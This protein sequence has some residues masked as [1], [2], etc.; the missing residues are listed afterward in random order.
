[1]LGVF[2]KSP[3]RPRVQRVRSRRRSGDTVD[4]QVSGYAAEKH[5]RVSNPA[6]T[7]SGFWLCVG[8]TKQR[9]ESTAQ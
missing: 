9:R 6:I 4:D 2:Q 8:Y 1:M 7:S 5:P 3:D